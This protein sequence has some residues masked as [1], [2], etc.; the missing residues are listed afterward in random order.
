MPSV[1]VVDDQE[2]NLL[3]AQHALARMG[4][5]PFMA[6]DGREALEKWGEGEF[7]LILVHRL[8]AESRW[9]Q[10]FKG[11][12]PVAVWYF[13]QVKTDDG[14]PLFHQLASGPPTTLLG[15][16]W[17]TNRKMPGSSDSGSATPAMINAY[18][19]RAAPVLS[20]SR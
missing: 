7:D 8:E 17:H 13:D 16:P 1:L 3:V 19:T 2:I 10:V 5:T 20:E 15:F 11:L 4:H 9:W 14:L 18:S 6:R 12:A